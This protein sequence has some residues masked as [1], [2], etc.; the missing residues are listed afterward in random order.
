MQFYGLIHEQVAQSMTN[1]PL[2]LKHQTVKGIRSLKNQLVMYLF[3]QKIKF[4]NVFGFHKN[5]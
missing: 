1:I 4:V 2:N 5:R 3:A